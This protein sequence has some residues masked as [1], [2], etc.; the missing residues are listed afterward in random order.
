MFYDMLVL[1]VERWIINKEYRLKT[2]WMRLIDE[3]TE[4]SA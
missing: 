4:G 3:K 1:F 2:V